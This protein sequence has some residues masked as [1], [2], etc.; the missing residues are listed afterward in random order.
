MD[1]SQDQYI[2]DFKVMGDWKSQCLQLK[3]LF[4]QL[5]LADLKFKSG[6]EDELLKRLESKLKRTRGEVITIIKKGQS[7]FNV[8]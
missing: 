1:T 5:T 4:P 8:Q 2:N 3:E 6:E 7:N